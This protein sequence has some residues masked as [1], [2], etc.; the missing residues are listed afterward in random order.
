MLV[1]RVASAIMA[2]PEIVLRCIP[3]LLDRPS[4]G[5]EAT[6]EE[7]MMN[8]VTPVGTVDLHSIL[9]VRA[10]DDFHIERLLS[11]VVY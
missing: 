5:V 1:T 2:C 8:G 11:S 3:L 6:S 4:A 9:G 7:L 10:G